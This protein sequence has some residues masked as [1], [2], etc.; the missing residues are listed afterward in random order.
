MY[1]CMHIAIIRYT[2]IY[3]HH[4]LYYLSKYVPCWF[5]W[6]FNRLEWYTS[7][8]A[9]SQST[10]LYL[11]RIKN[12]GVGMA[13]AKECYSTGKTNW[14]IKIRSAELPTLIEQAL[15]GFVK[16]LLWYVP[17][18]GFCNGISSPWMEVTR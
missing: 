6:F 15:L 2:C 4:T 11:G 3:I 17:M 10:N 9:L 5:T 14:L 16:H 13:I 12:Y 1:V 18:G 7:A 8:S